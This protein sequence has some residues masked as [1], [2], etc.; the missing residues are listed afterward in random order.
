M[1]YNV[2]QI[3]INKRSLP[4]WLSLGVFAFPFLLSFFMDFLQFPSF[5]KYT[6]DLMLLGMAI[7]LFFSK[8]LK[9]KKT[10]TPIFILVVV[11]LLYVT[12]VYIFN[13]QSI[14]YFLWGLRNNFRFY[15]V[16]IAFATF[17]E[18]DDVELSF[19]F[20]DCVFWI[21]FIV[22]LYQFFLLGY[23]QDY[24]GGI[25]GVERGCNAY[26]SILF[27]VVVTKSL[28]NYFEGN[29]KTGICLLKCGASLII[30]AMAELK[31]YFILFV[32]MVVASMSMTKFS[33]KKLVIFVSTAALISF[34]GSILTVLF[35]SNDE[36]TIQRII[37]LV[38]SENYAT[39]E[40]LG[41]FTAI[42]TISK[43]I[44]TEWNGRLFGMG[45]GNCDTS[46]FAICNTPFYQLHENLHYSWFSS[47]FLFLETGYIGLTLNLSFY[48]VVMIRAIKKLKQGRN[49]KL[50]CR[51]GIV[52][53]VL[54]LVLTFYNS[55]L[56]KEVG[57]IAYFILSIPFISND[58]GERRKME[59]I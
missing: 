27:A 50:Y 26:T 17:L 51:M 9:V 32:V 36:M 13:Y 42:P 4:Q 1:N 43:S 29:E 3:Q 12:V 44:L 5:T 37:E 23:Q 21:N 22:T 47:A 11:W 7:V 10:I 54:C 52:F 8:Q 41:R 38:T 30:A 18:K 35:G 2:R 40:D 57:Y 49:D 24:L 25:F 16:F 15:V 45:L 14:F 48:I 56:R 34:A 31:F 58:E 19:K 33:W 39:G 59:R 20:V 6:I 53:S 55:A 46:A 28:L